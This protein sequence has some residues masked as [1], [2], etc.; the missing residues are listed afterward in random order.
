MNRIR[1]TEAVW[2]ALRA[3]LLQDDD[4]HLAFLLAGH[5][6]TASGHALLVRELIVIDDGDLAG[7]HAIGLSLPLGRL[8]EVMNRAARSGLCLIEAHNHPFAEKTVQFS[9]IDREGQHE[10]AAHLADVMPDRP[11]GSLVVG[12]RCVDACVLAPEDKEMGEVGQV[13]VVGEHSTS[14]PIQELPEACEFD[15]RFQRQV[16]LLGRAGQRQLEATRI[17][18]VGL[19]GLGS[20]VAQQLGYLGV[21]SLI[22]VDGDVVDTTNLNRIVGAT[23][24]DIGRKKV[25]VAARTI[26]AASPETEVLALPSTLQEGEAISQV[27]EADLVIGCVD[28]D[29][30][31]QIMNELALAYL[32]P[33]IDC[34]VGIIAEDEE[35]VEAG[36]RVSVWV[37][38]SPCLLCRQDFDPRVAGEELESDSQRAFRREHGYVLGADVPEP[39]VISLNSTIASLAV[40]EALSLVTGFRAPQPYLLYDLLDGTVV[41]RVLVRNDRCPVCPLEGA[42]SA[43]RLDRYSRPGQPVDLPTPDR[44]DRRLRDAGR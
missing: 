31:R 33:L 13:R 37:P 7:E 22:L 3:H 32:V 27:E 43:A 8:L 1:I 15:R 18:V 38:G 39:S 21:G 11:Y 44:H 40:T 20:V 19:G 28:T 35:I 41:R 9:S 2:R 29:S 42:G 6:E 25:D 17:A 23:R 10:L 4:E 12:Q 5:G 26:S 14:I 34:G 36:G 30:G 24:E 16:L